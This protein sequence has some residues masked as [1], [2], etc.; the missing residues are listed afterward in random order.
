MFF[1][2][3]TNFIL[4][5]ASNAKSWKISKPADACENFFFECKHLASIFWLNCGEMLSSSKISMPL[6]FEPYE[7]ASIFPI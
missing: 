4:Q 3:R 2:N 1:T 6:Y 5:S 7:V